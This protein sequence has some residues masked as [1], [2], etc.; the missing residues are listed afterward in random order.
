MKRRNFLKNISLASVPVMIGSTPLTALNPKHFASFLNGNSDRILILIQL[1]GG[2]DGLNTVV[3]LDQYD[4]LAQLRSN[5]IL[6]ESSLLP[7][8]TDHAL[9]PSMTGIKELYD[10]GLVG[11]V[12]NV[13]YP[14]QNRSHFRSTDIWMSGSDSATV[15]DTGWMGRQLSLDHP[16]YPEEYPNM[17]C[18]D[19]LA[20]SLGSFVSETCQGTTSNYSI[21]VGNI[22]QIRTLQDPITD[23][24]PDNCYGDELGFVIE[25]IATTNAYAERLTTAADAGQNNSDAYPDNRFGN[26]MKT[27]ARL[28]SGGL[29]TRVYIISLG[30]FDTHANQVTASNALEGDHNN[31]LT[32]ISQSVHALF[33][34]LTRQNLEDQ[35][36][37]VT[38]SEFGRQIKSNAAFGTDHGTA[39]PLFVFGNCVQ[40]GVQ[41]DNVEI[42]LNIPPQAGMPMQYDFRD[43]YGSILEKWFESD[44]NSIKT[45]LYD[46][47]Q[48]LPIFNDSCLVGVDDI[49]NEP[50]KK[51]LSLWPNPCHDQ[52]SL[53]SILSFKNARIEIYN[54]LGSRVYSSSNEIHS[55]VPLRIRCD[56]LAPGSYHLRLRSGSINKVMPFIKV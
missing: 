34:D 38:F 47:F 31:L 12:Q 25:A 41:G 11:I 36:L 52:F 27:I 13:G 28:I 21:A 44:I 50:E 3:P 9:H 39:A 32:T 56:Q 48:S 5:I 8:T 26:E 14:D 42:P 30:G 33:D 22:D 20:L 53:N 4:N 40:G 18:P 6:P 51:M 37:C 46:D 1:N 7:I 35:I 17:D 19:P 15:L 43:V 16:G 23:H 24:L 29:K 54:H 2:N 10:S 49:L 55:N 45:I